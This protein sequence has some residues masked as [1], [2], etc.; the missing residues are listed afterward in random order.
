VAAVQTEIFLAAMV[1][2]AVAEAAVLEQTAVVALE[3]VEL[4]V[5]ESFESFLSP[6]AADN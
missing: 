2:W 4:E 6:N 1:S 5:P 3:T